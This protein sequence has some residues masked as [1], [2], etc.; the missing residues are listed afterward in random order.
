MSKK[1]CLLFDIDNTLVDRDG[2]FQR[3]LQQF[4]GSNAA[5]FLDQDLAGV[6]EK[7]LALDCHGKKDRALFCKELLQQFP[8]LPYSEASLWQD[9]QRLPEFVLK[10]MALIGV[11]ER[12]SA[13][14]HLLIISNG[15]AAMQRQKLHHAGLTEFFDTIF[16]SG[17]V[18][19]AKPDQRIF[20]HALQSCPHPAVVMI[21]DDYTND[22][23]PA[24]ALA[25]KTIF[26]NP[27][28]E[29]VRIKPDREI[30]HIHSLEEAL[31][32]LI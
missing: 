23:E 31:D 15:S 20:L 12:L 25:L 16:I 5:A 17:E 4:I 3:Y 7:I 24:L 6:M 10:D 28:K 22:M 1:G 2:A 26:I 19:C 27:R 8:G 30:A 14:F 32:C 21:G 18:G 9:C 11:L 13:I 29:S